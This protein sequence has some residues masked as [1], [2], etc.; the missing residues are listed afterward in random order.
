MGSAGEE[1][2]GRSRTGTA[3]FLP[4]ASSRGWRRAPRP[5]PLAWATDLLRSSPAS[6]ASSAS[7]LL[8]L[9]RI[10]REPS[11]KAPGFSRRARNQAVPQRSGEGFLAPLLHKEDAL[12]AAR[13][14]VPRQT[15]QGWRMELATGWLPW[16]DAM[17]RKSGAEPRRGGGAESWVYAA[18]S[19]YVAF[20]SQK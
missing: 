1:P 6:C 16:A 11:L 5:Q 10:P 20:R 9:S 15:L 8:A 17:L 2:H 18:E 13:S 12:L 4:P 14:R 19:G 3:C 7:S